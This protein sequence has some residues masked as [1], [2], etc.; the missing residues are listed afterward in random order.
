MGA[1]PR[2][3]S[4]ARDA[5]PA[6]DRGHSGLQRGAHPA[7]GPGRAHRR[8][9]SPAA[10]LRGGARGERLHR[11][12]AGAARAADG[13]ESA[14]ALVSLHHS[15]LRGGAE[16]GHARGPGR[17]GVLRRDRPRGP[18]LLRPG[19]RAPRRPRPGHGGGEQGGAWRGG[20]P[21]AHPPGGD[22][23]TQRPPAPAARVPGNG[24]PR[25][26]GLPPRAAGPGGPGL[27]GG[28]R[29]VRLGVRGAGLARRIP[30]AGDPHPARGEA[31]AVGSSH[32][33]RARTCSGRWRGWSGSSGW[34]G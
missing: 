6:A 33:P 13:G 16:A 17:A 19:A 23:G 1:R 2:S 28:P 31:P 12:D 14:A 4:S 20:P 9:R 11:R 10:G 24:H 7:L 29:R 25:A 18:E 26:Q 15:Q 22:A 21:A 3:R 5:C 8:A 27:R 32:G 34:G 30:G